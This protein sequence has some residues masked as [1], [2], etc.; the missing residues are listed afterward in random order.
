MGNYFLYFGALC[1]PLCLPLSK[2]FHKPLMVLISYVKFSKRDTHD[3]A[4]CITQQP[5]HLIKPLG[6]HLLSHHPLLMMV[7]GVPFHLH[8]DI[9]WTMDFHT[10]LGSHQKGCYQTY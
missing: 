10:V 6:F 2:N 9:S 8:F 3:K 4:T 1:R 7:A 5:Y